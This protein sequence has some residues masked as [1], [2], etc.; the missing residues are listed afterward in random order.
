MKV[1][2]ALLVIC[3]VLLVVDAFSPVSS[4]TSRVRCHPHVFS[5]SVT[6]NPPLLCR[7]DYSLKSSDNGNGSSAATTTEEKSKFKIF[8]RLPKTAY[9]IYKNYAKR[10]W[11]ET[12]VDARTRLAN[13]KVKG[14]IR[15]TQHILRSNEYADFTEA[16]SQARERLLES[17][18]ALLDSMPPAAGK[19][20]SSAMTAAPVNGEQQQT[21][22]AATTDNAAVEL[23]EG[24]SKGATK[25]K[26]RRSILF[27]VFM[28]AA[29]A[30]WVFSGNYLFTGIFCLMTILGQL[31]YYR[32][33]MNTGVY[34]ARRI[35]IIGACAM[36]LTVCTYPWMFRQHV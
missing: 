33:V 24:P 29:V 23:Q 11:S 4:S 10:L 12:S 17:C 6:T 25:K 21:Q 34:P 7:Y 19:G 1:F 5:P 14:A 9:R 30:C 36:F 18:D 31:E 16:S 13:E 3:Q 32:M 26:P 20:G 35:S 22:K 28:G 27:G 8:Y 15:N 2:A